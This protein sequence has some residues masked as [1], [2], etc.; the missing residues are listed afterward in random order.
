MAASR[1]GYRLGGEFNG[2]GKGS[3]QV[4]SVYATR[5]IWRTRTS[6]LDVGAEI[7]HKQLRDER[8]DGLLE[9]RRGGTVRSVRADGSGVAGEGRWRSF[10][11]YG[12]GLSYGSVAM[13]DIDRTGSEPAVRK[14]QHFVKFE[15]TASIAV[16][17]VS[18]LQLGALLRGQWASRSLDG[19]ERMSLGGPGAVRAYG[20]SAAAVDS[21]ALVSLE[22]SHDF[23][24]PNTRV[25]AFYDGATGRYRSA[26]GSPSRE[27]NL[28]GAGVGIN[29]AWKA[30]QAQVS[31][32]RAIGRSKETPKDDQVWLTVGKSF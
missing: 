1:V 22:A 16:A 2:L 14:R 30:M 23:V 5:P 29:W 17:P 26:F 12:A 4:A 28:Q 8:F 6:S 32:A 21:G 9:S 3:A 10:Y 27:V 18:S 19:S 24:F 11:R 31:L 15:P 7:D 25:S 20:L 13:T